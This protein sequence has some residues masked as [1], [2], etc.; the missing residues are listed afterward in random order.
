MQPGQLPSS[1][2]TAAVGAAWSLTTLRRKL[3]KIGAKVVAQSRY[4]LCQMAQVAVPKRLFRTILERIRRAVLIRFVGVAPG[5]MQTLA[6]LILLTK[7]VVSSG[8]AG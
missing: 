1:S 7:R 2:G 8:R 3:I 5:S 6:T 4:V